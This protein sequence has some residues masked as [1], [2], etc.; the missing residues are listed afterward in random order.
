MPTWLFIKNYLKKTAEVTV[1]D[2]NDSVRYNGKVKYLPPTAIKGT[3]ITS[4][5][6]LGSHNDLIVHVTDTWKVTV[7]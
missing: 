4:V 5:E 6:G 2:N 7:W 1:V 3:F